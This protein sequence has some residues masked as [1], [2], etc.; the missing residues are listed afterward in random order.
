MK[1]KILTLLLLPP[2]LMPSLFH[3]IYSLRRFAPKKP[4]VSCVAHY[5]HSYFSN[6]GGYPI[7]LFTPTPSLRNLRFLT[8]FVGFANSLLFFQYGVKR[9]F[10]CGGKI[11]AKLS[12]AKLCDARNL[13]CLEW[14]SGESLSRPL[15]RE[16]INKTVF[17]IKIANRC[18]ERPQLMPSLFRGIYS[19]LYQK[20]FF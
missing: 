6:T 14:V 4:S 8:S 11:G 16:A 20:L 18:L 10:P 19:L 9:R 1:I 12:K 5:V 17:V 15:L 13:R 7:Y 2:Q 3:G